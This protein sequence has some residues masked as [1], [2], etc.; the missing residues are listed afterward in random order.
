MK[1]YRCGQP[2]HRSN[3][4]PARKPVNFVD[5]EEEEDQNFEEE[6]NMDEFLDGAEITEEQGEHVN[7]VIQRV[8]CSTKLEDSTQRNNIFKT[9][10]SIQGK[11]CDLIVDSGS[12]ENFV[13]RKLVEHLKLRA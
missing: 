10:C 7:C 13:S 9:C 11:V 12:C 2:G 3:E 6:E 1:C 4:C 5:A 8:M